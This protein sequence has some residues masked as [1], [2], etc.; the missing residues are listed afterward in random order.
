MVTLLGFC[1]FF[2][3]SLDKFIQLAVELVSAVKARWYTAILDF[4]YSLSM[5]VADFL[6][7]NQIWGNFKEGTS[8]QSSLTYFMTPEPLHHQKNTWYLALS[9]RYCQVFDCYLLDMPGKA[10]FGMMDMAILLGPVASQWAPF[11][12]GWHVWV[13]VFIWRSTLSSVFNLIWA[14]ALR[15]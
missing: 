8:S 2:P 11:S 9:V 15:W 14:A 10:W 7:P 5:Q 12:K 13:G 6:F 3:C 4:N 1:S